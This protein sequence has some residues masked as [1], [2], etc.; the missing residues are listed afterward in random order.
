MRACFCSVVALTRPS[1][2]QDGC[3]L[4]V[5]QSSY[6]ILPHERVGQ[7]QLLGDQTRERGCEWGGRGGEGS[8]SFSNSKARGVRTDPS[9]ISSLLVACRQLGLHFKFVHYKVMVDSP[10]STLNNISLNVFLEQIIRTMFFFTVH[11]AIC[12]WQS[13]LNALAYLLPG[14][15]LRQQFV[16]T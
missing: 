1:T 7:G 13:F 3:Q 14:R 15:D 9:C 16:C 10:F 2:T 8:A 11:N 4:G 12:S 5:S 6:A